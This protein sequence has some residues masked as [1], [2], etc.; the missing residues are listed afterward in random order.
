[1][2]LLVMR[3]AD[4][5]DGTGSD[6]DRAL[7]AKGRKQAAK[8]GDW[9]RGIGAAPGLVISSPLVRA[10]QTADVVSGCF[11]GAL[12]VRVDERLSCGMGVDDAAGVVSEFGDLAGV[13]LLVGHAP[14]LGILVSHLIGASEGGVEMRKAAVAC[15]D[16]VRFG[17]SGS[18]LR[19][20]ITPKL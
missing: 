10:R 11:D 9:L 16:M 15:L 2:E 4:A 3:H 5:V 17:H 7:S 19:W 8:M 13:L 12:S 18:I 6:F 20:L 14:D 1:M